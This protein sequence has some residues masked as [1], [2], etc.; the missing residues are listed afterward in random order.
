ME[1]GNRNNLFGCRHRPDKLTNNKQKEV[2]LFCV[3]CFVDFAGPPAVRIL[4]HTKAEPLWFVWLSQNYF[5]IQYK[6]ADRPKIENIKNKIGFSVRSVGF[7]HRMWLNR[8]CFDF[9]I[10]SLWFI[11]NARVE[12]IHAIH[13]HKTHRQMRSI[14]TQSMRRKCIVSINMDSADVRTKIQLATVR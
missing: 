10:L 4:F 3:L 6:R 1:F 13:T 9:A 11:C 12:A 14:D 5:I 8:W 7:A 2:Y